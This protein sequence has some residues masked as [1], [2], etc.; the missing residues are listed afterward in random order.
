M[1]GLVPLH[2]SSPSFSRISG[3]LKSI[4]SGGVLFRRTVGTNAARATYINKAPGSGGGSPWVPIA[5]HPSLTVAQGRNLKFKRAVVRTVSGDTPF[6]SIYNFY[7]VFGIG[8]VGT[9]YRKTKAS[10]AWTSITTS[11]K[12]DDLEIGSDDSIW[13]VGKDGKLYEGVNM[14]GSSPSWSLHTSSLEG[15]CILSS[16]CR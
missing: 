12:M 3:A 10:G 14:S 11:P 15:K 4:H 16:S 9:V 1:C 5:G 13:G 8:D 2:H 7:Q 6:T